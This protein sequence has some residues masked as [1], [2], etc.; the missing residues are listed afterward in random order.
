MGSVPWAAGIGFYN[1][2]NGFLQSV[3][4]IS[5]H[6]C[7]LICNSRQWYSPIYSPWTFF[8]IF[9]FQR[10]GT[11]RLDYRHSRFLNFVKVFLLIKTYKYK[12]LVIDYRP[13]RIYISL[14]LTFWFR[15]YSQHYSKCNNHCFSLTMYSHTLSTILC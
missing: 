2:Y 9:L 12:L 7:L 11:T 1:T 13:F 5:Y 10:G 15:P 14:D 3:K 8:V 4:V 6:L